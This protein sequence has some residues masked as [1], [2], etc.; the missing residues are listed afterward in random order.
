[1]IQN[2]AGNVRLRA[3]GTLDVGN[4]LF[5]GAEADGIVDVTGIRKGDAGYKGLI[6]HG[7]LFHQMQDLPDRLWREGVIMNALPG[8]DVI[9]SRAVGGDSI[10]HA[11]NGQYVC[12]QGAE[13]PAAGD[14]DMDAF[15]DGVLQSL[16]GLRSKTAFF[17]QCGLVQIQCDTF[18]PHFIT[19]LD[20]ILS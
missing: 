5:R 18:D 2:E 8:G 17:I 14:D 7:F 10:F 11:G 1:M 20:D 4:G 19:S 6:D 13:G 15:G 9:N 3:A 12:R 16:S